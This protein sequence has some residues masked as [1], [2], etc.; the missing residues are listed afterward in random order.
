VIIGGTHGGGGLSET[1]VRL[2]SEVAR[3]SISK[4]EHQNQFRRLCSNGFLVVKC[5]D[6]ACTANVMRSSMMR[7]WRGAPRI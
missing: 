5:E 4:V 1:T 6:T 7:P 3:E 2:E